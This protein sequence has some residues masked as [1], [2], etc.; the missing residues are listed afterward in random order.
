[1]HRIIPNRTIGFVGW[2]LASVPV[3]MSK[4]RSALLDIGNGLKRKNFLSFRFDNATSLLDWFLCWDF[5]LFVLMFGLNTIV[6]LP[7]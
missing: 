1:M 2:L 5:V 6:I 3:A 7:S 4:I